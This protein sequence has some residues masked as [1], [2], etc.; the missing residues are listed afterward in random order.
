MHQQQHPFIDSRLRWLAGRQA[1]AIAHLHGSKKYPDIFGIVRFF[2]CAEGVY[3]VSSF[4]GLPLG[5]GACVLRIFAMHIHEGGSCT[6]NESDPF[7]DTGS[8]Y[9]PKK[10]LHP[11]HAGDLPPVFGNDGRA[12]G[13]V[14]TNRFSVRDVLGKTVILHAN[15]DDFTT[16]PSGN[17]GEKIAC[18]VISRRN[19]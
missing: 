12:W 6:G 11:F 8:H 16:Q 4:K 15:L 14:L 2:Q 7:A 13:A 9:N 3:V 10:C 17:A 1:D 18:G 19:A 5:N